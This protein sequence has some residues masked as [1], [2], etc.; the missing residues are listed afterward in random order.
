MSGKRRHIITLPSL[1]DDDYQFRNMA[2]FIKSKKY[3]KEQQQVFY[4]ESQR[5]NCRPRKKRIL[6]V[7]DEFD[8]SLTIKVV[9]EADNFKVD[10]FTD[11][12][13]ALHNFTAGL[14]D[15]AIIDVRMPVMNGFAL[16]GEFKKLDNNLKIC[17]LTAVE[18]TY[19]EAFRKQAFPKYDENCII[20][21]PVEN[22]LL[23]KQ[24]N[25]IIE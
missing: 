17:F 24:I 1:H 22:E 5:V 16:Y 12:Q 9:L 4:G 3:G 25:S 13:A 21:K 6:V 2:S 8:T 14:Y 18:D 10:S 11:P 20:R 23:I 15:L 19:Y 7:D